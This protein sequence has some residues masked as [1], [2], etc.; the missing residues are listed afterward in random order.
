MS[1]FLTT[2]GGG[3][4]RGFGR[5]FKQLGGGVVIPTNLTVVPSDYHYQMVLTWTNSDASAQTRIYRGGLL[6]TTVTAGVTTYTDSVSADTL[7]SYQISH[8]KNSIESTKTTAVTAYSRPTPPS[9]SDTSVAPNTGNITVYSN[10]SGA[11][12]TLRV[13]NNSGTLINSYNPPNASYNF[14]HSGL[15]NNT[16]YKYQYEMYNSTTGLTSPRTDWYFRPPDQTY[17]FQ[18]YTAFIGP[19]AYEVT[20]QGQIQN[21]STSY[22]LRI[23]YDVKYG[24]NG[25]TYEAGNFGNYS[26]LVTGNNGDFKTYTGNSSPVGDDGG[27]GGYNVHLYITKLRYTDDFGNLIN[28]LFFNYDLDLGTVNSCCYNGQ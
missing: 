27:G 22:P 1:P 3:S 8:Y 24:A 6:Q 9:Y 15:T 18:Y 11:N 5:G 2:L 13:Y 12:Y 20:V 21:T 4:V 17:T 10:S 23:R 25:P 14:S 16:Q 28:Y 7:Y 26:S 19:N